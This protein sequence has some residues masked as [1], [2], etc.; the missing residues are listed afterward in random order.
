MLWCY[1]LL[2]LLIFI[3]MPLRLAQAQ[4]FLNPE[5]AFKVNAQ[6]TPDKQLAL[7]FDVTPGYYLYRERFEFHQIGNNNQASPIPASQFQIPT[8]E[9]KYDPTF[10]KEM[11]VYHHPITVTL[12]LTAYTAAFTLEI[13]AQGCADAGLCY[14]P[15]YFYVPITPING[16]YEITLPK[17]NT[18]VSE[19]AYNEASLLEDQT[20]EQTT[21]INS[22][23]NT[24]P[25]LTA[26][27]AAQNNITLNQNNASMT[28]KNAGEVLLQRAAEA[29]KSGHTLSTNVQNTDT[30]TNI[31]SIEAATTATEA[32]NTDNSFSLFNAGDTD[33]ATW[34]QGASLWHMVAIAFLLGLALS[35]TP[36]VLPMLPILLSLVVGTQQQRSSKFASTKLTLFYVLGTSVVYTLL[37]IIAASIGA[38]L[39]N[40]IQ[41]PWVLSIFALFLVLFGMAM[42]GAYNFQ[43]PSSVQTHLN[44]L[45]NKLPAGQSGGA[46]LMGMLSALICG[47]CVAAPLAGVLLFI[48]QT[49]NVITGAII[50]FVLAW[51]QG[52]SLII[53]GTGSGALLPKAGMWMEMVK[54][55]CGLLLFA[56]ALWMIAPL[57][58]D[59]LPMLLWALISLGFAYVVGTF[60]GYKP[61]P[62]LGSLCLKLLGWV[63]VAWAVLLCVGLGLGS[64]SVLHPLQAQQSTSLVHFNRIKSLDELQSILANTDKPVMLDFYA[65]WCISCIE[66]EKFT[67]SDANV[68]NLMK[69]M[70]LLQV[71]VT[72]NTSQ[73]RELLKAFKLFGPPGIIFFN[74]AGQPV[75]RV[76]GFQN[77]AQFTQSLSKALGN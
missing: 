27:N 23:Q 11:E 15:M 17:D 26:N 20:G 53:L 56:A 72:K 39:A 25:S 13:T 52:A 9:V 6:I 19:I 51:G 63:A 48:S 60:S 73:D 31:T 29:T 64:R 41:N 54:R 28:T 14:P 32:A 37:G 58:P 46:L 50:L 55:I 12:P 33:I 2:L 30:A 16:T 10:D 22:T 24:I 45:M 4:D 68:A 43:M 66:M 36:C 7:H 75:H 69:Q 70:H 44:T 18:G 21:L 38:A 61:F 71:D 57:L 65:D 74:N 77:A 40:W 42:F 5:Q 76:I 1:A 59:W 49:G 62:R 34:L 8:G 67:F 47:P 3:G 35:F